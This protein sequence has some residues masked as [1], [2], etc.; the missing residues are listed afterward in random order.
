MNPVRVQFIREQIAKE[1]SR[2]HIP[3]REQLKTLDILDVG[4]GGGL[5][6]ES[7]ARLGANM[8][9]IDP[10]PENIRIA[11]SHKLG[12]PLT[13]SID[14]QSTTIEELCEKEKKFDVVCSLEV[15]EHVETPKK[16]LQSC[17]KSLKPNGNLF[18]STINR[19]RKS[20]LLTIVGAEYML[21]LVPPGIFL[22]NDCF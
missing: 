8:T 18:I 15:L 1:L 21:N 14:Y 4:C 19:T 3:S 9:S 16:F 7:L 17:V 12:D 10:S 22:F 13:N 11:S 6:S 5:L 2:T 20:H